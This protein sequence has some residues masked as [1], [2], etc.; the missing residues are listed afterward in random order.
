MKVEKDYEE[1][2]KFLNRH[3]VKYCIIGAYAVAFYIKPRYTKDI[4]LLIEASVENSE[5][6]VKALDDFGFKS[7]KLSSK[8]FRAKGKIIQLGYEPLRVDFL[9]SVQGCSFKEAWE[10]REIG[11]YGAERIYF[12]GL[13]DLIKIKKR[14]N[15]LQD[16][17]DLELLLKA[18]KKA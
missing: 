17:I 10:N 2:F 15:R 7:L 8:D 1:L 14:S 11:D 6:I 9:T 16:K 3:K 12:I 5:R 18:K 4:D 13:D